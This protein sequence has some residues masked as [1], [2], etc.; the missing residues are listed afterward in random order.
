MLFAFGFFRNFSSNLH[1]VLANYPISSDDIGSLSSNE[2]SRELTFQRKIFYSCKTNC[3]TH[4]NH[5]E[6]PHWFSKKKVQYR[7]PIGLLKNKV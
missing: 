5:S 1:T 4:L 3:R 6:Y 2:D 7:Q